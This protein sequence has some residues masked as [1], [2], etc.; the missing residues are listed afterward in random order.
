M[1]SSI[2]PICWE[3]DGKKLT[4][5][6]HDFVGSDSFLRKDS[7]IK[8]YPSGWRMILTVVAAILSLRSHA[9]GFRAHREGSPRLPTFW[10]L[11][12]IWSKHLQGFILPFGI[13]GWFYSTCTSSPREGI[14]DDLCVSLLGTLG[15][16]PRCKKAMAMDDRRENKWMKDDERTTEDDWLLNTVK[17]HPHKINDKKNSKQM[18][19]LLIWLLFLLFSRSNILLPFPLQTQFFLQ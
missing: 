1:G 8:E 3:G 7:F 13:L 16:Y 19:S 5:L 10:Y 18:S 9:C 17:G 15:L 2:Q 11:L 6:P 12:L 4:H 14:T